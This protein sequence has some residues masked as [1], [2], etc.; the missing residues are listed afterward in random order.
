MALSSESEVSKSMCSDDSAPTILEF[1]GEYPF[2]AYKF[3][4]NYN[5]I[6]IWTQVGHAKKFKQSC[7]TMVTFKLLDESDNSASSSEADLE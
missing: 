3:A 6:A 1:V 5:V 2:D 7:E 4:T